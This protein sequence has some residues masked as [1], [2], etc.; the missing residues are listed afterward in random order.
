LQG[1]D[2][3][4]EVARL[5]GERAWQEGK[6]NA[7]TLRK[8]G[9]MNLLLVAMSTTSSSGRTSSTESISRVSPSPPGRNTRL[10]SRARSQC[11]G[12]FSTLNTSPG[13]PATR[14]A[15]PSP[16]TSTNLP[17]DTPL[18]VTI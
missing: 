6:R 3:G 11:P 15:E 8:G 4:E 16:I 12:I 9:G 5:R 14:P 13:A 17:L 1:F 10:P 18:T 7:I 2:L